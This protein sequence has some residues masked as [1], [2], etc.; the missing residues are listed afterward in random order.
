MPSATILVLLGT[1]TKLLVATGWGT[2]LVMLATGTGT[3]L[4]VAS[5]WGTGWANILLL[6]ATVV[7]H[8]GWRHRG[9][10]HRGL[11]GGR[12]VDTRGRNWSVPEVPEGHGKAVALPIPE[13]VTWNLLTHRGEVYAPAHTRIGFIWLN[14]LLQL[15]QMNMET[16]CAQMLN[17]ICKECMNNSNI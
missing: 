6:L 13:D 5:G 8:H 2:I 14:Q 15:K 16:Y 4:L 12:Q 3:K 10:G 9:L 7:H 11:G 1:V 17:V